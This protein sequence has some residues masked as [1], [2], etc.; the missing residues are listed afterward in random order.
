M[1][2]NNETSLITLTTL[3][4]TTTSSS[5]SIN[6]NSNTSINTAL[7]DTT[8]TPLFFKLSKKELETGIKNIK[9]IDYTVVENNVF[10]CSEYVVKSF[11]DWKKEDLEFT[12]CREGITNM[13][14]KCTNKR[15]QESSVLIR[16]YGNKTDVIIDRNQEVMNQ[17]ALS[18]LGLAAPL[19]GRFNN[20]LVYGFIPGHVFT[21]EDMKDPHKSSLVAKNMGIWHG[22]KIVDDDGYGDNDN[23]PLL[24]V[25]LRNWMNEVQ[26]IYKNKEIKNI[27]IDVL[28]EEI[29][30]L[31][32]ELLKTNS[33]VVFS[34]NDLLYANIIYDDRSDKVTFIDYEYSNYGY[35]YFDI[36]NHFNEFGGLECDYSLYPNKKFQL[37]WLGHYLNARHP[38][39]SA[40][41]KE[42]NELYRKVNKFSLASHLYWLCWALIQ[43][44]LST[45]EFD[46]L[47]YALLRFN[48]Y[49]KKKDEFLKL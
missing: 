20:G 8:P 7:I 34:H 28:N 48:E 17:V 6:N 44:H 30:S 4:T 41:E 24:F 2:T 9:T 45:I 1:L 21:V 46:Y 14:I 13:L 40:T 39:K 26:R 29:T 19:Y 36:A 42:T 10:E 38:G 12:Q 33:P 11:F 37:Q 22:V 43:H 49:Y 32:K 23:K 16:T 3:T 47:D 35:A 31:E 27:N 25:T 18:K 5:T 15:S